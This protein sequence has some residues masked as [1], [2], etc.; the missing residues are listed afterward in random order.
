[1]AAGAGLVLGSSEEGQAHHLKIFP[2]GCVPWWGGGGLGG[3]E[4]GP[5]EEAAQPGTPRHRPAVPLAG[6]FQHPPPIGVT[7][8]GGECR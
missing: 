5:G 7:R 3:P 8:G 6:V 4:V 2:E 1:M